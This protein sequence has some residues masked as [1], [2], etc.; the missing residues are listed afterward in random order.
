VCGCDLRHTFATLQFSAGAHFMQMSKWLGHSTFTLTL[1]LYG[2]YIP[3]KD[4]GAL[5]NLPEPPARA[6]ST[7]TLSNFV[8]LL[9]RQ[10]N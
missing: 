7:Q 8:K 5:N 3:A 9:G 10:A 2:D 1:E 4:G 6:T